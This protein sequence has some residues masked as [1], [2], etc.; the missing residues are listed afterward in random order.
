MAAGVMAA[1][2][3]LK[4]LKSGDSKKQRSFVPLLGARGTFHPSSNVEMREIRCCRHGRIWQKTNGGFLFIQKR[5]S[6]AIH[7]SKRENHTIYGLYCHFF[8]LGRRRRR[9][10]FAGNYH[11]RRHGQAVSTFDA[12][13]GHALKGISGVKVGSVE[14]FQGQERRVIVISTVR[15]END[16]L[17]FD[18]KY[19]LGFVSNEKTFNVAITRV[20]A[21]LIVIGHPKVLATDEARWLP[22]LRFCKENGS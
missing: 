20:K 13:S 21:L 2:R 15:T 8:L 9:W 17:E 16:L 5:W 10:D 19:N 12:E 6:V 18:R 1:L 3:D 7:W 14:T 11:E 4:L 22:L